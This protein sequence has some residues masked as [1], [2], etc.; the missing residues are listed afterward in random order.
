MVMNETEVTV[1][2]NVISDVKS[3]R[4]GEGVRVVNFRVA[5]NERRFDKGTGE[6]VDGD[7]FFVS[8]TCWRKLANGVAASLSKGDPVVVTGR[9]YTRGY[10]VEGQRRSVTEIEAN[11][12][13]PD[14]SRCSAE[15]TRVRRAATEDAPAAA[16]QED[17]A[18]VPTQSTGHEI[19]GE[20]PSLAVVG[21]AQS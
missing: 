16:A 17:G 7:R 2:G 19:E 11:A 13:G 15:L 18:V 6:W 4:T 1:V 14:L 12:V 21:S 9:L 3:R 10:E 5:S 20:R 8:V